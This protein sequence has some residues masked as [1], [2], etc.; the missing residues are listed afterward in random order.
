[1]QSPERGLEIVTASGLTREIGVSNFQR[2]HLETIPETCTEPRA[3]NQLIEYH[4][5]LQRA[6][7]YVPWMQE[8][9]IQVSSFKTLPPL[10]VA[11]SGP[12][13]AILS[14]IAAKH[15]PRG[16]ASQLGHREKCRPHNNDKQE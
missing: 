4:P 9:G 3:L 1:M 14:S 10:T 13:N 6:E 12:L 15:G 5:Y 8:K 11:P 7:K 2:H 16:G